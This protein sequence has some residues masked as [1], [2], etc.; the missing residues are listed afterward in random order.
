MFFL[1]HI[2]QNN[3][4]KYYNAATTDS[5]ETMAICERNIVF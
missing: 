4:L 5:N 2:T 1:Q 3:A